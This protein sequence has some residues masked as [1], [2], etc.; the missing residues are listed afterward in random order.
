MPAER[1]PDPLP[2]VSRSEIRPHCDLIGHRRHTP[3]SFHRALLV[4]FRLYPHV[5]NEPK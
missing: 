2:G 4:L 3:Q 5:E 1:T